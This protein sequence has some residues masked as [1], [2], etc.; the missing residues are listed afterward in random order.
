MANKQKLDKTQQSTYK[1]LLD[2]LELGYYSGHI[3][4]D[5]LEFR[6]PEDVVEYPMEPVE[7]VE[8]YWKYSFEKKDDGFNVNVIIRNE[9][10]SDFGEDDC[11][12]LEIGYTLYYGSKMDLPDSL[13]KKFAHEKVLPQVWPYFRELA[14]ELYFKAGLKWVIIPFEPKII[15]EY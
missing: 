8:I 12:A 15:T 2:Q 3:R 7:D 9:I 6:C 14:G 13:I 4:L 1:K 5:S 10:L 11:I